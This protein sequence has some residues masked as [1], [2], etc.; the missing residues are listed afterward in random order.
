[1]LDPT[2]CSGGDAIDPLAPWPHELDAAARDNEGLEAIGPQTGEQFQHRLVDEIGIRPVELRVTR[3]LD[4]VAGDL[5]E[6]GRC[7]AGMGR[8]D[9]FDQA[10]LAGLGQRSDVVVENRPER[11]LPLPFR[12]LARQRLHPVE[13]KRKLH[14]HR[15]LAPQRAV[16]VECR[17]AL[18]RRHEI[19]RAFP[20]HRRDEVK[21]RLLRPAVIPGRKRIFLRKRMTARGRCRSRYQKTCKDRTTT[22]RIPRH[23]S[24]FLF[25]HEAS[26]NGPAFRGRSVRVSSCLW[27]SRSGSRP[28][29]VDP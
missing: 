12:M 25:S 5:R 20:R 2:T 7:H 6:L 1:M 17:D 13:R 29:R 8:H 24:P 16:I 19:R 18:R 22:D 27:A 26:Q 3:R 15:L 23:E 28:W 4:P 21:D 11:L 10:L 14:I 9:Q